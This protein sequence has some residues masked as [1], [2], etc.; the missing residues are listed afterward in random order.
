MQT[1]QGSAVGKDAPNYFG[2]AEVA[3]RYHRVRPLYH[4]AVM[5]WICEATGRQGFARALDVGCG[6]GHSTLALAQI[7]REVVGVDASPGMLRQAQ[8]GTGVRYQLGR[9]EE[10]DFAAGEFE[11]VTVGSALH[12]F[13]Q[14]RF[15]AECQKVLAPDGVLVVYNDHFT[16]HMQGSVACKRWMRTRF[17]KRFPPPRRGMRDMDEI[18]AV[19]G[20]FEVVRRDSF[21]HVVSFTRAEFMAYL[22]T[23]SNTL[24]AIDSGRET[25]EAIMEWLG[26]ELA[27]IVPENA[28]GEFIF[29]CNLW[30]LRSTC[31]AGPE[32]VRGERACGPEIL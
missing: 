8:A 16:A 18:K 2:D 22:M 3:E 13:V 24:A 29:K 23:R 26:G 15:Y 4:D 7:A 32:A 21:S 11:L 28:G 1:E 5:R 6:S 12:W 17:A 19:Q 9:A 27:S 14:D 10:L 30:W 25:P 20:G 31:A